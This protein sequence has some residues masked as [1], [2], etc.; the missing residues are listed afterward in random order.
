M[1]LAVVL[2]TLAV[3]LWVG[4]MVAL[5]LVE[6]PVRFTSPLLTRNQAVQVGQDIITRFNRVELVLA[7]LAL[8]AALLARS[9]RW[10]VGVVG[11]MVLL[12]VVQAGYLAPETMRLAQGLDFV[13]RVPGDPRYASIR[14]LHSIYSVLEVVI[15][16]AGLVVLAAWALGPG[17][18]EVR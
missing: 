17:R 2:R 3:A 12:L 14:T 15:L 1:P 7:L 9:P 13:N 10:T 18:G 4:G 11:G 5:D 6:A 16:T 8:G